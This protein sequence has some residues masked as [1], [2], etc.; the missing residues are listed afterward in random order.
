MHLILCPL[1]YVQPITRS[2]IIRWLLRVKSLLQ[3]FYVRK[4]REIMIYARRAAWYGHGRDSAMN[5][6]MRWCAW[7]AR[8]TTFWPNFQKEMSDTPVGP[9]LNP[10]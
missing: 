4:P 2:V 3:P 10:T 6:S 8:G 5:Y 9:A 7:G 1:L